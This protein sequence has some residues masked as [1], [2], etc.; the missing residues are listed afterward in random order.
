MSK[1]EAWLNTSDTT[2]TVFCFFQG[3]VL[4]FYAV[5]LL[6]TRDLPGDAQVLK[7]KYNLE[8]RSKWQYWNIF[9][10][11][12]KLWEITASFIA[13]YWKHSVH[14]WLLSVHGA[15]NQSKT[16]LWL[17]LRSLS[18][19]QGVKGLIQPI[20]HYVETKAK[21]KTGIS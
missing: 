17:M 9:Q 20:Q 21:S 15:M 19:Y 13:L 14:F 6:E 12:L 11:S 2:I 16:L 7:R 3:V 1:L 18:F 8:K 5:H 4:L 10:R